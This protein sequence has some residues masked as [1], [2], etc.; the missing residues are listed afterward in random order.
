MGEQ[1]LKNRESL[2]V[3]EYRVKKPSAEGNAFFLQNGGMPIKGDKNGMPI[4]KKFIF[5]R[6]KWT[7][8]KVWAIKLKYQL[9]RNGMKVYFT[10]RGGKRKM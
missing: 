3:V 1:R 2:F 6:T 8:R 5:I 10:S 4:L 7:S 9:I